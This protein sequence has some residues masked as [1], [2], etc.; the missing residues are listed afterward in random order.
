MRLRSVDR[1]PTAIDDRRPARLPCAV[2]QDFD[3]PPFVTQRLIC[4][5]LVISVT[6]YAVVAALVLQVHQGQGLLDEVPDVLPFF[7]WGGCIACALAA[8]V[9]RLLFAHHA[10]HGEQHVRGRMRFLSRL[11]PLAMLEMGCIAGITGWLLSGDA[12]PGLAL[13]CV[14]LAFAI[15]LVP[16]KP[17]ASE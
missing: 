12:V 11:A 3:A 5:C 10:R 13:A 14:L 17:S 16:L 6:I 7:I 4:F 8:G 9:T 1:E 2:M 15:A